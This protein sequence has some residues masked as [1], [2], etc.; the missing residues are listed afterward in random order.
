ML[1]AVLLAVGVVAYL[2]EGQPS[3][4]G[5]EYGFNDPAGPGSY[6]LQA[7]LG[8]P[9]RRMLVG[10]NRVQPTSGS[11]DWSQTDA[12]YADLLAAGLR[13]LLVALA[14]PCWAHPS[15][16]CGAVD[17]GVTPQDPAYDGDWSQFVRRLVSRY[18]AAVGI[19]IWN[20]QNLAQ[21]FLPTPDPARYTQLLQ[22]AYVAVK[23]ADPSMPVISGG[24]FVSPVSGPGGI[25]DA[26]F[27]QGMYAAGAKGY[28]D[29]IGIH[30]YP[31]A[32]T[33]SGD[34]DEMENDLNALRAVRDAA[35]DAA[36]PFWIT[37]MGISTASQTSSDQATELVSLVRQAAQ[38]ADVP[39][40]IL[41][42]LIDPPA[43]S[44]ASATYA[45]QEPGYGVFDADGAPKAAA[46]ALSARLGGTLSC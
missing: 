40:A 16:P 1:V 19:E 23:N 44:S 11:W 7:E 37:E 2:A 14:P 5:V 31:T 21:G 43:T 42:R 39:V 17:L 36:T 8:A 25:G 22:Q 28:M 18:P 30:I 24:L 6:P 9:I 26:Q 34:V 20:E 32:G 33:A 38:D 4:H 46:C 45:G 13:P 15:D 12:E 29:G 3:G 27:L 35:G 41:H 10:W